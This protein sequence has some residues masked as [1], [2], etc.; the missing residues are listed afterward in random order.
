MEIS[1]KRVLVIAVVTSVIFFG[2]FVVA[3]ALGPTGIDDSPSGWGEILFYGL[4]YGFILAVS[5]G[6]VGLFYVMKGVTTLQRRD[7]RTLRG[8]LASGV[9]GWLLM[10]S[11][12]SFI[13]EDGVGRPL[14]YCLSGILLGLPVGP[15]V[16]RQWK[17]NMVG[18]K[19]IFPKSIMQAQSFGESL[20]YWKEILL[21]V[22]G[23]A[24]GFG[25]GIYFLRGELFN[26][27]VVGGLG[28]FAGTFLYGLIWVYLYE[29][30][31]NIRI[32]IE[33]RDRAQ[34]AETAGD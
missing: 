7:A 3:I 2:I 28:F 13:G 6:V 22:V 29:R 18:D 14:M 32:K 16:V 11:F 33:Y 4:L 25:I 12:L 23:V 30:R 19:V 9:C 5:L 34:P 26:H 8:F 21:I 10:M 24:F 15:F 31:N 1:F 20:I 17:K 27:F